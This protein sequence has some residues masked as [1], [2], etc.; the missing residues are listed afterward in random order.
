MIKEP[1]KISVGKFLHSQF[2][3]YYVKI[4]LG[5]IIPDSNVFLPPYLSMK[6]L[7]TFF[8]PLTAAPAKSSFPLVIQGTLK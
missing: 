2:P 8:N 3:E 7:C 5:L 1:G 4:S 6:I